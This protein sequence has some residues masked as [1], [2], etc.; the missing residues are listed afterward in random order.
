MQDNSIY[1][2]PV[3]LDLDALFTYKARVTLA[4][5]LTCHSSKS[6]GVTLSDG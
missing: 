1:A 3:L 5:I 4:H 6:M 2:R